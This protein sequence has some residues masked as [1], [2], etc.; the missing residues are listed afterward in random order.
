MV[1][2]TCN[3]TTWQAEAGGSREFR[4][5]QGYIVRP[6]LR[7][8]LKIKQESH[9]SLSEPES[10]PQQ[11]TVRTL[12]WR[13]RACRTRTGER[14][15]KEGPGLSPQWAQSGGLRLVAPALVIGAHREQERACLFKMPAG[16]Q[17]P[18]QGALGGYLV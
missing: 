6:H 17:T 10:Q 13:R 3:P 7:K 1:A 18:D 2:H 15:R 9:L 8:E 14:K 12:T 11:Q 16:R 4:P 5:S